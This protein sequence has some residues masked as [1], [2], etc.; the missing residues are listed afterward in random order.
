MIFKLGPKS[1]VTFVIVIK[2]PRTKK[3]DFLSFLKVTHIADGDTERHVR[4]R[5][6]KRINSQKQVIKA[7]VQVKSELRVMVI[8]KLENPQL[9]CCKS[10]FEDKA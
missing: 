7:N 3:L 8:G 1:S 2:A 4:T 5:T 9:V 10:I 6:E